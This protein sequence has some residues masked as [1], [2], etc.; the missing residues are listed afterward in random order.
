MSARLDDLE[1][2]HAVAQEAIAGLAAR[3]RLL[4]AG[5]SMPADLPA[6]P[7]AHSGRASAGRPTRP[8]GKY[9]ALYD[10]LVKQTRRSIPASF[11]EVEKILGAE[12]PESAYNY[13]P[14]WQGMPNPLAR[15]VL[16]AGRK[17]SSLSLT[18]QTLVFVKVDD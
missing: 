6:P 2:S 13:Q 5:A 16:A 11:A 1:R 15:A 18:S 3:V 17:V 12:L 4:E 10:W 7:S 14:Y 9:S 8:T